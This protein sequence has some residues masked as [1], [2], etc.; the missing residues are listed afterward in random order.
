MI[1][2]LLTFTAVSSGVFVV[3]NVFQNPVVRA[4]MLAITSLHDT[5]GENSP[6][7]HNAQAGFLGEHTTPDPWIRND[8]HDY[9]PYEEICHAGVTLQCC[10]TPNGTQWILQPRGQSSQSGTAPITAKSPLHYNPQHSP[11]DSTSPSPYF[12]SATRNPR[13]STPHPFPPPTPTPYTSL[14]SY[15]EHKGHSRLIR[16]ALPRASDP[17][18]P[19]GVS[20]V[21]IQPATPTSEGSKNKENVDTKKER[22]SGD[23]GAQGGPSLGVPYFAI[24]SDQHK[25]YFDLLVWNAPSHSA[26]YHSHEVGDT[27]VVR[28]GECVLRYPRG[29][30]SDFR[31][32][33][34]LLDPTG[35]A[36]GLQFIEEIRACRRG[37]PTGGG[38]VAKGTHP[39]PAVPNLHVMYLK[40]PGWSMDTPLDRRLERSLGAYRKEALGSDA[41]LHY[42]T[43]GTAHT[44]E[45]AVRTIPPHTLVVAM[46]SSQAMQSFR[47]KYNTWVAEKG[48]QPTSSGK[49][50]MLTTR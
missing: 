35:V 28:E 31:H 22:I 17:I 3:Y 30:R 29:S 47:M 8:S 32:V 13:I 45:H 26:L 1:K 2:G 9:N 33:L 50:I 16:F 6:L 38:A 10:T 37:E 40:P 11:T 15:E 19:R 34:L 5:H 12:L 48:E 49:C 44:L 14:G 43:S 7:W 41:H 39:L 46:L 4:D 23:F 20:T 36:P 18:H 42:V 25:G 24:P 27:V 21:Y